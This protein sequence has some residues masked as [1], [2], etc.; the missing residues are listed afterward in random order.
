MQHGQRTTRRAVAPA[1]STLPASSPSVRD[2]SPPPASSPAAD[3]PLF[4]LLDDLSPAAADDSP[5]ECGWCRRS[6]DDKRPEAR[7][8][9]RKC[10]QSAF[11]LR[12]LGMVQRSESQSLRL[13]YADPPY[14]G[15]AS[16]YADQPSY[17]GE[18]DHAALITQLAATYDGWA[19]STGAYA[20]R[21]V[22]PLC[23]E[24]VRVAA[25][26]KPIGA[27]P[28]TYGLHNCWEPLIVAPA[29]HLRPGKR[30]WLAAQPARHGGDLIG[31]KPLAF[32]SWLFALLGAQPHDSLD[33]LFPG[34]GIVGRCW[35]EWCRSADPPTTD[36]VDAR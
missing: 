3:Y 12:K 25:W 31:R 32:C 23:P 2:T 22:L 34:T 10:R 28:A 18:V 1:A 36:A 6:I 19:L 20:L 17:G 4:A 35:M 33:D 13:A 21:T 27:N 26:V 5:R 16:Y 15:K 14:P 7:F 9:S 30:D 29:R 8:C 24:G 11:R